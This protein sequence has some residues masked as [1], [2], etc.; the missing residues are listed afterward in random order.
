MAFKQTTDVNFTVVIQ[1]LANTVV[2]PLV[3]IF[4]KGNVAS[5]SHKMY[6]DLDTLA[7]DFDES[8]N[9]YALAEA[10]F[11]NDG[12]NGPVKVISAPNADMP[13]PANVK[14]TSDGKDT[15]VTATAMNGLAYAAGLNMYDGCYIA[16]IDNSAFNDTDKAA[17][18]KFIYE[19]QRYLFI[20][21]VNT[22]DA[23][24]TNETAVLGYQNEKGKLGNWLEVVEPN[25]D[26]K[27]AAQIGA[28]IAANIPVD[29]QHIGNL[30]QM[31]PSD[32]LTS[33]DYETIAGLNATTV[34]NKSGDNMM[35]NGKVLSGGYA[36]Q[37]VNVNYAIDALRASLQ[38]YL[39]RNKWPIY[40]DKT[41]REMYETILATGKTLYI[42]GILANPLT[43]T[44]VPRAQVLNQDVE[45]REYRGFTVNAEI[46]STIDTLNA[47]INLTI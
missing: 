39:N 31:V 28:Y 42:A 30:T 26:H 15:T 6:Y 13:T 46:A 11:E 8:T 14:A 27:V 40:N 35:L 5:E 29:V 20:D 37:A 18:A 38:S 43:V 4:T 10:M 25:D 17:F 44:Y 33:D 22:I 7:K 3:D 41:I 23:A 9:V 32:K 24:Q 36:D 1:H 21:Q 47:K 34:V 2:S 16:V 45:S 12:F 19:Q